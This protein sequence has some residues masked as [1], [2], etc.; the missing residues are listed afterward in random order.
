MQLTRIELRFKA[1]FNRWVEKNR[2]GSARTDSAP[3]G[4]DGRHA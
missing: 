4:E 2:S 1:I 3:A